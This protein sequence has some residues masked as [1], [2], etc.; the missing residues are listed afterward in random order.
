M[1]EFRTFTLREMMD[2]I[3]RTLLRE[4]MTPRLAPLGSDSRETTTAFNERIAVYNDG[5]ISMAEALE[6]A[7]KGDGGDG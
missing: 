1:N 4:R 2:L 5:V 7:L 6:T 3:H